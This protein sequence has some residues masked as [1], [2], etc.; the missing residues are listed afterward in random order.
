MK[1]IQAAVLVLVGALGAMLFFKIKTG[2]ETAPPAASLTQ[3]PAAEATPSPVRAEAPPAPAEVERT[4]AP[5]PASRARRE[6]KLV[7]ASR[8]KVAAS[9]APAAIQPV[10]EAQP[11]PNPPAAAPAPA[12]AP[13]AQPPA[14]V[15]PPA[16]PPP[17]AREVTLAAGTLLPVRLV[18]TV[19]SDRNH[20]GDNFH[21]SLSEPLVVDGLVI[22]EKGARAEG[23]IVETQQAG[24]VKGVASLALELTRLHTSDGQSVA[25]STASFTKTGPESKRSDAAK[26][27]GGAALGAIIGAIAGGG[28]GAAIGAGV[29]GAAG[30]GAVVTTRGNPAVLPSETKISF[31]LASSVTITEKQQR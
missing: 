3:A 4:A 12:P 16:P 9:T 14:P 27:G 8:P 29:G 18:E 10:Q 5:E 30:T 23:R 1:I 28:K 13:V 19:S 20:P 24:K 21:A 31:R 22:A 7:S 26:I 25:I 17:P 11:T 2:P 15:E 6:R